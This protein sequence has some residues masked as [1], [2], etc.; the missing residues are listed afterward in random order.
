MAQVTLHDHSFEGS[1]HLRPEQ[2][3]IKQ[4]NLRL[5]LIDLG[6]VDVDL[7]PVVFCHGFM[8]LL[9]ELLFLSKV[10]K[11]LQL[12]IPVVK[13]TE[14]FSLLDNITRPHS[15]FCNVAIKRG[16]HHALNGSFEAGLRRNPVVTLSQYEENDERKQDSGAQLD[17]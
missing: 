14:Q 2:L 15:Y 13:E 17:A 3:F 4:S 10:S 11:T 9:D 6:S 5:S 7:W 1:H 16:T 12:E 8:I